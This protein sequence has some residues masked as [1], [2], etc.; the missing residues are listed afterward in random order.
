MHQTLSSYCCEQIKQ[1][2]MH[3]ELKPG[4]RIKGAYLK[5]LLGVGLSPIR[6]ALARLVTSG[7]IIWEDNLGFRVNSLKHKEVYDNYLSYIKLEVLLFQESINHATRSWEAAIIGALYHLEKIE[8]TEAKVEYQLWAACND[9]FHAALISNSPFQGLGQAHRQLATVKDW[10]HQL[11]YNEQQQLLAV[12]HYE[13]KSLAQLALQ[14]DGGTA[15]KLLERHMLQSAK[16]V[17][18]R[19]HQLKYF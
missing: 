1:L 2:I 16:Y 13:H 14:R 8:T 12:N 18:E 3:G 6:E 7:L 17:V 4:E 11:A 5:Q 10:Y 15:A 19:F 9:E